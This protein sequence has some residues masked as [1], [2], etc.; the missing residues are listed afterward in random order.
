MDTFVSE[1]NMKR[2]HIYKIFSHMPTIE[3]GRF[4]LRKVTLDD[5]DDMYEYAKEAEV[6][7][8]LTWSPHVDKAHTFE[9][10]SYLQNRYKVGDFFDWAVVCKDSGKMIG[11]CGFTRFDYPSNAAEIGYVL[12]PDY[13]G[14]GIATEVL[15]RVI[16][17][18]F[19]K[20]ALNRIE[21]RYM[22]ENP[23]SRRVMEKNGM[24]FEGVCRE[25]MLIKGKYRNIGICSILRS[26]YQKSN[27]EQTATQ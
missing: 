8:Y 23:A 9:Y 11:T 13:H 6:T 20:L 19:E 7:K 16:R 26:E 27:Q 17:F 22:I 3:T 25:G 5:V 18:G 1:V 14:Q 24:S 12:N 4:I 21:C 10:V 2:E 15:A